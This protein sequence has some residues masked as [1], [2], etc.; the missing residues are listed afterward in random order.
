MLL[1]GLL[2]GTV[3][4]PRVI[5][6]KGGGLIRPPPSTACGNA[7]LDAAVHDVRRVSGRVAG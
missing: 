5:S 6:N 4:H 2:Q 7:D 3:R 1:P